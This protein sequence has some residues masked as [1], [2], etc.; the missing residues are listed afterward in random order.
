MQELCTQLTQ[1]AHAPRVPPRRLQAYKANVKRQPLLMLGPPLLLWAVCIALGVYGVVAGANKDASDKQTVVEGTGLDWAASFKLTLEQ[2]FAPLAALSIFVRQN[3]DYPS[4][5][6]RFP[7]LADQLLA[8]VR[9]VGCAH[10]ATWV[11]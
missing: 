10:L 5:A 4:L 2:T 9:S 6:R 7:T 1:P 8:Q 11:Q 3:P